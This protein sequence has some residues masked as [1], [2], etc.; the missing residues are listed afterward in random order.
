M[1][2]A[3]FTMAAVS[4]LALSACATAPATPIAG[5]AP[6]A[7]RTTAQADP[8]NA[9]ID[10]IKIP[11]TKFTLD[12]GLTVLVHEDRKAPIVATSIWYGVGS[13]NEPAGKTGFAHLFEH[14]MFNGS[15]NA[16]DDFFKYTAQIGATDQN[17]S[18][19]FDRTNYFQTVPKPALDAMLFLES[20]RMGHLLGAVTQEKLDNQRGVVQNEKRQGDNNPYGLVQYER[21]KL[22]F[23][24]QSNPYAHSTIGSMADLDAA[25]LTDVQ[26]WF[27]DH[28]AP[29]NAVL[30][31]AG[32][33]DAA[34]A[35]PLV[36]KYF[37]SFPRGPEVK[38]V[39][40]PIPTLA[41][42]V[43]AV[44]TDK[45]AT[46]RLYRMWAVPG[47]L[48]EDQVPLDVGA[49][50]LG[51]LASSRLD[52]I[53][54][55]DEKLAVAVSA[56]L[57]SF[58]QM[59]L[60]QVQVDV[61]PGKDPDAVAERLDRIIADLL[62]NGP[63][64]DEVRR[65]AFSNAAATVSGLEQVG[66]FNGKAV[67]LAEGQLYAGDPDF[68]AKQLRQ[69]AAVTPAEVKRALDRWLG[70]PAASIRVVP[71]ERPADADAAAGA[72]TG[73]VG[74]G[75][76][77]PATYVPAL[78]K[79]M[80]T[81]VPASGIVADVDRSRLPPVGQVANVDF[82]EVKTARL[83][84][85]IEVRLAER[86]TVPVVRVAVVFD[87]GAAADPK[88]K[89][90]LQSLTVGMLDEGTTTLNARQI[91]ETEERLGADLATSGGIDSTQ[92]SL[93]ALTTNLAPSL[94]LLADLVRHPAFDPAELERV[95]VAT[96]A[97]IDAEMTQPIALGLR[98]LGPLLYG[99]QHPYGVPLTG[100]GEK[101]MVAALTRDDL[102]AFRD[103][104]LRPETARIFVAGDA[105]MA[106][107]LPLL[108][109]RFG[110][111]RVAGEPG[112]KNYDAPTPPRQGK[113][114]VFDR[115]G[116]PQ[117]LIL[118]GELLDAKGKD[119]LIPLRA[120]N[121]VLGGDFLS[122]LNTDLRETK[123]WSYGVATLLQALPER[124]SM[125]V[126]APV[127][128]D[129]TGPSIAALIGQ[130]QGFSGTNGVQPP[131][132]D[133]VVTGNIRE[134]PGSYEQSTDVLAQMIAD[135]QL[136]RPTD[137]ADTLASRYRALTA[138]QLDAAM[139]QAADPRGFTWLVVGDVA[140][141]R[142]QLGAVGLPVVYAPTPGDTAG[143]AR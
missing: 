117:S 99:P 79:G 10:D 124:A 69:L 85:G 135:A 122:R 89:L 61:A 38:P 21:L 136:G 3:P 18:T 54:V 140:K 138:E 52:N 87:A 35:R 82:P 19:W 51:G 132:L 45:V 74:D 100:S 129:K 83:S 95:R 2:R 64:A 113:I 50:V 37:G 22:L 29:N 142:D 76:T 114:I 49:E 108:E 118:G 70:R 105:T 67:T 42:P 97:G 39:D 26:N 75:I 94:D 80:P 131:E 27:R 12:N 81:I 48:S 98:Q 126:Y 6:Q 90:G 24:D 116:S 77:A 60:F 112:V 93:R 47:L 101:P 58:A 46:T 31:L 119:D 66:G 15:E 63:T 53:L 36:E 62:A 13:K 57:Q 133:R 28:Y 96:L 92:V 88:D 125:L 111:W 106:E 43:S 55:R 56:S 1:A 121:Q 84:N 65:V 120:A 68:Y 91:A 107:I 20:D 44:M 71:G 72:A 41:A 59:G 30:V 109:A 86:H 33:I 139:R 110:D 23:P 102:V 32:D 128:T 8:L 127:Q 103:R 7:A 78:A 11:Y 115:P 34:E 130:V 141:I 9:L 4:L 143:G 16:P 137:Y 104:W 123:G 73:A 134:L 5:A 14:L 25:S 17:G 40:A